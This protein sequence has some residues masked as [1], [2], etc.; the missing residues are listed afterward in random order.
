MK[1]ITAK[2]IT[3][4]EVK[5]EYSYKRQMIDN[6][7]D[8]DGYLVNLGKKE[9][10]EESFVIHAN[11]Q[12]FNADKHIVISIWN[13]AATKICIEHGI[14]YYYQSGNIAFI[15]PAE[16]LAVIEKMVAE[17]REEGTTEEVVEAEAAGKAEN[18]AKDVEKAEIILSRAAVTTVKNKDGSFYTEEQAK[19]WKRNYNNVMNEGDE[20]G[21]V[22]YVVTAE[23]VAWAKKILAGDR[24]E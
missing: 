22:P 15:F 18:H 5:I 11:G 10:V 12:S 8:S 24:N 19:V 9:D 2:T 4:K 7:V 3:G 14:D 13:N 17:E 6:I 21:Y 16:E 23:D 1:T 20:D